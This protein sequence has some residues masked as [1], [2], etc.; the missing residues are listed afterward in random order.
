MQKEVVL[1]PNEAYVCNQ[2][3]ES[4]LSAVFSTV[5]FSH[6]IPC[7]TVICPLCL[8]FIPLLSN[9]LR[10]GEVILF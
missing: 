8:C 9:L 4:Y 1:L 6:V 2:N 5:L 10:F 3:R 7:T